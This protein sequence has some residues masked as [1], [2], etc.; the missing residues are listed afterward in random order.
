MKLF[1]LR[2]KLDK[3]TELILT[4]TGFSILLAL[5]IILSGFKI[6]PKQLLPTPWSVLLSYPELHFK[7]SLVRNLSYSIYLNVM[8]YIEATIISL[9][10]GFIM[11][12]FP[13]FRGLFSRIVN[14]SRFI[15]MTA[16][17]G[18][19][20]AWFGIETNMKIQFLAVG[21]MVYLIPV[22]IQRID[23]IEDV[24]EQT[25]IMLGASYLQRV[26]HVYIPSVFNR[27][28]GDIQN[29]LAIS[30]TYIIV[31]EMINSSAG[32]IGSL[33][34]LA[35]KQSR[36]DKVFAVLF[37]IILVGFIQDRLFTWLDKRMCKF[38]YL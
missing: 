22:V 23:E 37:V 35:A 16:V 29:L 14:S 28:I 30:W 17:T 36:V 27:I 26:Q 34:F 32:G 13:I 5:W 4:I 9:I 3:Q 31:C 10:V 21:I 38:K 33:A 1:E 7:D 15:P 25:A 8:G 2:G 24:Y 12:L 20:I 19:F 6:I 18:L 11:G